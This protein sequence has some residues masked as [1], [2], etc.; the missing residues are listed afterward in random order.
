M[1]YSKGGR[2]KHGEKCRVAFAKLILSGANLLVLDEPTN[3]LDII[4][5]EKLKKYWRNSGKCAAGFP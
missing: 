1:M 5:K 3:H 2:I 4:S